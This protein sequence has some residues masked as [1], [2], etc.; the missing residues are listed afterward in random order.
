MERVARKIFPALFVLF[1]ATQKKG[2]S[3]TVYSMSDS[4][5]CSRCVTVQA[6]ELANGQALWF[7]RRKFPLCITDRFFDS[8]YRVNGGLVALKFLGQLGFFLI[9]CF[10]KVQ[11]IDKSK[12]NLRISSQNK[13]RYRLDVAG[14]ITTTARAVTLANKNSPEIALRVVN[15]DISFIGCRVPTSMMRGRWGILL[16]WL[17][18]KV[19]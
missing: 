3:F 4:F 14:S 7:S 12:I 8:K 16:A 13:T 2:S 6:N 5:L 1:F 10:D 15:A 9:P 17:P 19:F 11:N 18:F